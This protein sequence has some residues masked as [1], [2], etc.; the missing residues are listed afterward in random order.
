MAGPPPQY[1]RRSS[2]PIARIGAAVTAFAGLVVL[3][4]SLLNLYTITV[5]PSAADTSRYSDIPN[6][7]IDVGIGFYN[8][9]PLPAPVTALAIPMLMVVAAVTA[10]PSIL[11]RGAQ[12]ALVSAVASI[13]ATLLSLVLMMS[14]PLPSVDLTGKLATDFTKETQ[15]TS[16]QDLVS[17]VADIGPGAGLVIALIF[18]LL[19][20]AGAVLS[21]LQIGAAKAGALPGGP[22]GPLPGNP[23]GFPQPGMHFTG[24]MPRIVDTPGQPGYAGPY[25]P[26]GQQGPGQPGG[27]APGA[28]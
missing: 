18:G 8:V 7:T 15:F 11:G 26:G 10:L 17:R 3:F 16:I 5:T 22:V 25:G 19:G 2:F 4:G 28:W 12:G 27:G 24:Q 9:A 21:Y 6:G 23:A 13:A 1:G 20:S 14:N